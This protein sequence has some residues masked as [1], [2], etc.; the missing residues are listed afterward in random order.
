MNLKSI[1]KKI[2]LS[3]PVENLED[4][5]EVWGKKVKINNLPVEYE[6]SYTITISKNITD[7]YGRDLKRDEVVEVTVPAAARYSYF[8]NTGCKILE[9]AYAPK[10][11]YEYQNIFDGV[12]KIH[13]IDDPYKK[14]D[15]NELAPYDFSKLKKNVKHYEILDLAPWLTN[16][17]GFVGMS[18]NFGEKNKDGKRNRWDK[19]DLMLQ[20]TDIGVTTRYAYNKVIVFVNSLSTGMPIKDAQVFLKRGN[21][22]IRLKGKSDKDGVAIFKLKKGEYKEKFYVLRR[23]DLLRI[24]VE[25]GDDKVEF[26]PNES[27]NPYHFG[28]WSTSSP[29]YIETVKPETFM[30]TDRG[31]YKPGE[32]LRFRGIDRNLKVGEYFA[33]KGSYKIAVRENKYKAKPFYSTE[34]ETTDSGGFYGEFDM[35]E[36]I[37]PGHYV[38]EYTRKKHKTSVSFKVAHFRRLNFAVRI[39]KPDITYYTGDSVWMKVKANYLAGGSLAGGNYDYY[40]TKNCAYYK[41]PGENWKSYKFGPDKYDHTSHL[42]SK[43]GKLNTLGEVMAKQK[44]EE[45][46]KGLAYDYNL[47]AK[48]EDID[49]QQVAGRKYVTVHPASFYIGAKFSSGDDGWWSPFVKKGNKA[50]VDFVILRPNGKKYDS[51]DKNSKLHIKLYR[52]TWKMAKQKGVYGRINVRYERVEELENKKEIELRKFTGKFSISP[53]ECGSYFIEIE[54]EDK[55]GRSAVTRFSFYSTGS[56]WVRWHQEGDVD[57]KLIADKGE[58]KPGENAKLLVQS[59]IPKGKYLITVER[60]GIFE[61]KIVELEGSANTIDIPVKEEYLPIFYVAL[62][63]FSK[64]GEDP[65]KNYFQPDLGKPKGY[66]GITSLKVSTDSKELQLKILPSKVTYKPGEEAEVTVMAIK[67]GEPVANTEITFM[68]TDRGVLDLINYHVRNPIDFFYATD[69]FPLGVKG[70]D[71]RALLIDPVTYAMKDLPGGD[72][73]KLE[74][75]KDFRPTAIF[76]PYLK[77]DKNGK[78]KVKFK[79]PDTLT[80]YRCTAV[81]V[82]EDLFG[83]KEGEVMVQN[84]INVRTALPRRLR[85]RDTSFAGVIVMNL[86]SKEHEVKISLSSDLLTIDGKKTKKVKVPSNASIEVPF[87]LLAVKAGEAKLVFTIISDILKEELE[88][89]LIIEKPMI[90]EA[91]TTVGKTSGDSK[92]V[93]SDSAEEGIVIPS[94]IADGYGGF[95]VALDST[96]LASLSESIKYLFDYPYG[97]IEQRTSRLLP[98]I[99]FGDKIKPFGL[100]SKI[101]NIKQT[102]EKELAYIAKFQNGDGGFAFWLNSGGKS[103]LYGSLK[104]CSYYSLCTKKWI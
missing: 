8:P 75:R 11:I 55:E 99:L 37:Q 28:I 17:K 51:F 46:I 97:C 62:S 42:S 52:T 16:G 10:V 40:W 31:L 9:A 41:P 66:F 61:E 2:K 59:P 92:D 36:N 32:T 44:T 83:I 58:Y 6:S 5:I 27:H 93:R 101:T 50:N 74:R 85:V 60:E 23:G 14:F 86:D 80:T 49:R 57:I 22:D 34:G 70:A 35:P 73:G 67:D 87:K 91:F 84:P 38:I 7:I 82:K 53:K 98:L 94:N 26:R 63:S 21:S 95:T 29:S 4:S 68:A 79:L 3:I 88:D 48:I 12:W 90:K 30:F 43:K 1:K 72:G 104:I 64:R 54:S 76:E 45:G 89:K 69:K 77:T 19:K 81:A 96:R 25:K 39:T 33:Y 18:W 13:S 24:R 20:V 15:K 78:A 103:S 56:S 100:E 102:I 71:S 47:E 65:P